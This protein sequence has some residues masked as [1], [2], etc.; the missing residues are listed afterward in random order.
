[1]FDRLVF[2]SRKLKTHPGGN[3]DEPIQNRQSEFHPGLADTLSAIGRV[4][5]QQKKYKQA[6]SCFQRSVKIYA[7][8]GNSEQVS[9][10]M[11][12]LEETAAR[13][14]TDVTLTR[15]FVDKW[16]R[17]EILEPPCQ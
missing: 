8:L 13:S 6:V 17:G 15:Y 4:Y 3:I 16:S 2:P 7:L 5:L 14:N 10:T 9:R 12:I 11:E 1:M